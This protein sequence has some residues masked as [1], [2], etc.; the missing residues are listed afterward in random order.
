ME[1]I[2]QKR[3]QDH[4]PPMELILEKAADQDKEHI[5][6]ILQSQQEM[7]PLKLYDQK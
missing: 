5:Q 4:A 7:I 2:H 1:I 6:E 3:V